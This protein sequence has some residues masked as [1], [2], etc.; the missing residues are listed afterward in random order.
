MTISHV[1]IF[2]TI[3]RITYVDYTF[4]WTLTGNIQTDALLILSIFS[5]LLFFTLRKPFSVM[6]VGVMIVVMAF[7]L[8]N[9]I[10]NVTKIL[11]ILSL[12]SIILF[13]TFNKIHKNN[14][15]L[16]V[17]KKYY[18][19]NSQKFFLI[20]FFLILGIQAI[21]LLHWSILPI[22]KVLNYSFLLSTSLETNFF[23]AFGLLSPSLMLLTIFSMLIRPYIKYPVHSLLTHL[24][25]NDKSKVESI[26]FKLETK[27]RA[28]TQ[29]ELN[30]TF[31]IIFIGMI[32]VLITLYPYSVSNIPDN[33]LGT[34]VPNYRKWIVKLQSVSDN[35]EAFTSQV[36]TDNTL[37]NNPLASRPL[38]LITIQFLSK[39]TGYDDIIILKYLPTVLGPSLVMGSYYLTRVAY[40]NSRRLAILSS[41]LTATSHQIIIG[42]YAA[43]Y[44]NWMSIIAMFFSIALL[45]KCINGNPNKKN[46][47]LFAILIVTVL[48]YHS[49]TWSYFV[50]ASLLFLVW[51]GVIKKRAKQNIRTI[52][53]LGMILSGTIALDVIRSYG[54]TS[55]IFEMDLNPS[56]TLGLGEYAV[57]WNNL[58][59]AF[60][61]YLGGYLTNSAILLLLLVWALKA[62]Y[63]NHSDRF[64]L[65]ML[66]VSILPI[67]FGDFVVQSRI[68]YNIPFQIPASVMLYKIYNSPR[69]S[70]G[71]PLV[72][73][74]IL[75]QFNYALRAMANMEF[76]P[77]TNY[78]P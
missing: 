49:F 14:N 19:L 6:I 64:F 3:N 17:Q 65:S 34:D 50:A 78:L 5:F 25:H 28:F 58:D 38:S 31:L 12:P 46:L 13:F 37:G 75:M 35:L 26:I 76:V 39:I 74:T 30:L 9:Y 69:I 15:E 40:P 63:Q 54:G 2:P 67:L 42:F 57:R 21:A 59:T 41:I 48:F 33:S 66:F 18:E 55:N 11:C 22:N 56:I 24:R 20:L 52:L 60:K 4:Y 32:T 16:Q 7:T 45:L 62:S 27:F 68:F 73:A 70:F 29:N 36:F 51:T 71:K 10:N 43:Y 53:I 1:K 23:Y 61:I 77:P 47:I 72:Y 44:A 8:T